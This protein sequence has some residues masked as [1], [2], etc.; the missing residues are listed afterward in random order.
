MASL[1]IA[2]AGSYLGGSLIT[3]TVLGLSGSAIGWMAG[4]LLASAFSP[5]QKSQ[6]PRLGDLS[7][8]GSAYGSTIPFVAGHPRVAGQ[9]VWA[10]TKR[11]VPT[12][13][14][15]GNSISSAEYTTFS[16][17]VDLLIL[18]TD[19]PIVGVSRIWSNGELVYGGIEKS[20]LWDRMTV[21]GGGASQLPD[22]TYDA[23]VGTA[24]APAYRGRGCVFIESLQLGSA[25]IMQNLTFEIGLSYAPLIYQG[26]ET[27]GDMTYQGPY[28]PNTNYTQTIYSNV[29]AE[30]GPDWEVQA[31]GVVS[32]GAG[33]TYNTE[34]GSM[35]PGLMGDRQ[36][37]NIRVSTGKPQ[38]QK[39]GAWCYW[40][41]LTID[42]TDD[43]LIELIHDP[44][45]PDYNQ[46]LYNSSS[47]GTL[48]QIGTKAT[49]GSCTIENIYASTPAVGRIYFAQIMY[50]SGSAASLSGPVYS[51]AAPIRIAL[52]REG[53]TL[54]LFYNGV[55]V[56][57]ST[58]TYNQCP[59]YGTYLTIGCKGPGPYVY[60][61]SAPGGYDELL[62][63]KG[64]A[65]YTD[66]YT[67]LTESYAAAGG[68]AVMMVFDAV[69]QTVVS[70]L[71][72]R[73]GVDSSL[74]D[75]TALGAI[76]RPVHA[77]AISQVSTGRVVLEMLAA[78]YHF[79]CLLSD[80]LYMQP[81]D[82]TV[83]ATLTFSELGV[84]VD[85]EIDPLPLT[86]SNELE[87][88]AQVAIT[89]SNIDSDYQDDTQYSDRLLSGQESTSV[90]T[91][92]L[93]FTASEGKQISDT[94]LLDRAVGALGTTISV[95]ITRAALEPCDVLTLTAEDG[96]TY[97]MRVTK[98]TESAG[99]ITLSCVADDGS[100][101][102]QAGVTAGGTDSQV[103][104]EVLSAT[105][106]ALLDIPLLRD[107]D[108]SPGHYVAVKGA[109]AATWQSSGLYRSLDDVT[110]EQ[111]IVISSAAVMG[112]CTTTLGNHTG[113]NFADET[114]TLTVSVGEGQLYSVTHEAMLASTF[115]NPALVGDEIIQFREAT[116]VSAGVYTLSGLLR[117]K[118]GTEWAI[119]GHGSA[120]RFV[121][122]SAAG[123][124]FVVLQ[125]VD[126][127]TLA[128]Y[129]AV[130]AGQLLSAVTAQSLTLAANNLK[131]FSPTN[132]HYAPRSDGGVDI[133]W[134]RRTRLSE[135]WLAGVVPLGHT[136]EAYEIDCYVSAVF[137]RKLFSS[138]PSV[139]Y[140]YA[141]FFVDSGNVTPV[142]STATAIVYQ[143]SSSVGL[144]TGVSSTTPTEVPTTTPEVVF[145][146]PPWT[147]P[148]GGVAFGDYVVISQVTRRFDGVKF[149][150]DAVY[151]VY[152]SSDGG[153]NFTQRTTLAVP[154]S[155]DPSHWVGRASDGVYVTMPIEMAESTP[156]SQ[157][158]VIPM[159]R[160]VIGADPVVIDKTWS[161][162]SIP[163]ALGC[164]GTT[165]LVL[166]EGN[167]SY[168]S[169]DGITWA[170]NG[171]ITGLPWTMIRGS[172]YASGLKWFASQWWFYAN[173][174]G[175]YT[176]T[177]ADA[178]S[179][180]AIVG[181]LPIL[182]DW[183]TGLPQYY[184]MFLQGPNALVYYSTNIY[185]VG[186]RRIVYSEGFD[187]FYTT[188]PCVFQSDD[189]GA[190]WTVV[191]ELAVSEQFSL[192]TISL[193]GTTL[194]VYP[195]ANTQTY[196]Y[197]TDAGANWVSNTMVGVS[198][199]GFGV[200]GVFP[201]TSGLYGSYLFSTD[202][203]T[204]TATI[205]VT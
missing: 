116:L 100:V 88:P 54:R 26:F 76:T 70:D 22:P 75:V 19:N 203:E 136:V 9:V 126:I 146:Y 193:V 66:T 144:G 12:T 135:N 44:K 137:K 16:Y 102:T 25:G 140:T 189:L 175:L 120:E 145:T 108:D 35:A 109:T 191:L 49:I 101:F 47:P 168:T 162:G 205:G 85:G 142:A 94:L 71:L 117:G 56:K 63:I 176:T 163:M 33:K 24:N 201:T 122:L 40:S 81:R 80:K 4:S 181:P 64:G 10:S 155:L 204:F 90:I 51:D 157:P 198:S 7:V 83:D 188:R 97:R 29:T 37:Q 177:V 82:R 169:T 91:L 147:K 106:L 13:T 192:M 39:A 87:I 153:A 125:S 195:Y 93:G 159:T 11:E 107:A 2:A 38:A 130:T 150:T 111:N 74:Y 27:V 196:Y 119:S 78:A 30:I 182:A 167:I 41:P 46:G 179:G 36:F 110:Y 149:D 5:S 131:T 166:A 132:I 48:L 99:I 170:S 42:A 164:D 129:K 43:F 73:C 139:T 60:D 31:W 95:G 118:R 186:E 6:G 92:P 58:Q 160:G 17:E 65:V 184:K 123:V 127:G 158:I 143:V 165:F 199:D 121:Q 114:N 161:R 113:G 151:K 105:T 180:W 172:M 86:L 28:I 77:M 183:M 79:D 52:S 32:N 124:R 134:D 53:T 187:G 59:I 89:F 20:G 103:A 128:Y 104:V 174:L 3:G 200:D 21:Y 133:T 141:D 14:E 68:L 84:S 45:D 173:A 61:D 55:L 57:S 185:A 148:V 197:S 67:P 154:V 115:A 156:I 178:T 34:S 62:I 112:S 15:Q 98:R 18:L 202:G 96:D 190:T 171:A 1:V 152:E 138:T 50:T 8:T 72:D 23:A 69:L 194:L